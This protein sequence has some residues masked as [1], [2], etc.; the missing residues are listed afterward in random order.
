MCF[1]PGWRWAD[2]WLSLLTPRI[3]FIKFRTTVVLMVPPCAACRAV[4]SI[5]GF[6]CGG[7]S[8]LH[9]EKEDVSYVRDTHDESWGT[10]GAWLLSSPTPSRS[11]LRKSCTGVQV[12][13]RCSLSLFL[14]LFWYIRVLPTTDFSRVVSLP[15]G[16]FY[17]I[18][19][20]TTESKSSASHEERETAASLHSWHTTLATGGVH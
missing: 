19:H 4:S 15:G 6:D 20:I 3:T 8:V 16:Y 5:D 17:Y 11:A 2:C 13:L 18:I 10:W 14:S 12:Q 1:F 7:T 9:E